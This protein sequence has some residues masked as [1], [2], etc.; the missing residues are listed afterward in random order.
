MGIFFAREHVVVHAGNHGNENNGVVEKMEFNS[1]NK[2]LHNAGGRGRSKQIM[3]EGR[4]S[5]E[6][7]MLKVVPELDYQSHCPPL[8]RSPAKS[9]AQE[10]DPDEHDQSIPVVQDFRVDQPGIKQAEHASGMMNRPTQDI[11]LP[12]LS[13]MLGPVAKYDHH[14]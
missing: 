2:H 11:N 10:P 9:F 5:D 8:A 3:V 4:L 14:K 7:K 1:G 6:Q 12:C 13:D